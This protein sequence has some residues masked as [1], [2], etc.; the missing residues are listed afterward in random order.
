MK[1]YLTLGLILFSIIG[2]TSEAPLI[3]KSYKT[4]EVDSNSKQKKLII[5]LDK[6]IKKGGTLR[7]TLKIKNIPIYITDYNE[8][9]I[10]GS[11]LRKSSTVKIGANDEVSLKELISKKSSKIK[12]GDNDEVSLHIKTS[13]VKADDTI[14]IKYEKKKKI[15]LKIRI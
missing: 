15:N 8:I 7:G 5:N 9:I 11:I 14:T 2:C 1:K 10:K 4:I 13:E 6:E 3:Q 12:I